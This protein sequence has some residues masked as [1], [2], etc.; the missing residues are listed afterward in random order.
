[1]RRS[2]SREARRSATRK[3]PSMLLVSADP[4]SSEGS[5][6]ASGGPVGDVGAATASLL[7]AIAE[8]RSPLAAELVLCAAFGAVETGLPD[9]VD[10]QERLEAL[11]LMLGQVIGHGEAIASVEALTLLRVCSVLGPATS[12]SAARESAGRLAAAGVADLPWAGRVGRPEMLRAWRYGDVF[13]AQSS[14]GVLFD[15]RGREHVVMVLVDHLLGGGVKDCWVSEGRA[16]KDMRNSVAAAMAAAGSPRRVADAGRTRP[17]RSGANISRTST[18]TST[19]YGPGWSISPDWLGY[20]RSA[21]AETLRASSQREVP[22][23]RPTARSAHPRRQQHQPGQDPH[24][25]DI[26]PSSDSA[27]TT[28]GCARNPASAA[29]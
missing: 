18:T 23:Q 11:A 29:A 9:D 28:V 7:A 8:A 10:E 12:R 22:C 17:R 27:S 16:A 21:T 5:G 3:Q 1:M 6:Q 4:P 15:Y 13:G 19:W 2:R 14:V 26:P 24:H 20:R 25:G